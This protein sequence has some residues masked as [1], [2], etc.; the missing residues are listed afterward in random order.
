MKKIIFIILLLVVTSCKSNDLSLRFFNNE[1][2]EILK[3]NLKDTL[4]FKF[5]KNYIDIYEV[6][7]NKYYLKDSSNDGAFYFEK[8]ETIY[9]LNPKKVKCLKKFIRNSEF[10]RKDYHRKLNDFRLTQY[11]GKYVI[12][13]VHKNEFIHVESSFEIE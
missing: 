11:F 10:Y 13:L 3:K 7:P 5:D 4:F 8:Q 6:T 2:K 9:N 12:F 1:Q